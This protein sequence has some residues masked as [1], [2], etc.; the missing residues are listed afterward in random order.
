MDWDLVDISAG[1]L[2][3]AGIAAEVDERLARSSCLVITAPPGAGKSTLLPLTILRGLGGSGKILMLEPRRLAARQ[4][5]ERMSAMIGEPVGRTVGYRVRFETRVSSQ[6]RIEVLTEGILTRMLIADP[7]LEGVDAVVF[8]EFHERSLASDEALALTR[9]CQAL[10]R[11]DLKIVVM[12]ATIDA[13][14]VCSALGA[15]LVTCEGRMFTVEVIHSGSDTD[16]RSCAED[17]ARM[18]AVAHRERKGDI[19]AFL[20]GEG[21]I[22]RCMEII[23]DALGQTRVLPLYGQLSAEEQKLAIAPSRPG[24]RKVVL[25][26][27]VAETSITIEGVETVIDSGLCRRNVF[28]ARNGLSRLETVRISMDMADQRS[29]R[30]G[31]VAPGTCYRLWGRGTEAR[32][33]ACRTPEIAE[34]DLTPLMLD[35]AAWG[36]KD[37]DSLPWITPPPAF[38]VSQG[39]RLLFQLGATDA[40]GS[41][42]GTGRKMAS[43]P[44]HPRISRM[45]CT[46]ESDSMKA[47]ACDIAALLEEKDPMPDGGADIRTRIETLRSHGGSRGW[48]RIAKIA[49]QYRSMLHVPE[50]ASGEESLAA[51]A[52]IAAAYPE[53]IGK[54]VRDGEFMLASGDLAEVERTDEL[55]GHE[56]IAAASLNAR[57]G[58]VGKIFLG[59]PVDI[60]DLRHMVTTR[61]NISWDSRKGCVTAQRESR[62]GG[63]TVSASPIHSEVRGQMVAAICE[64][65]RKDG[66]AMLDFSDAVLNLQRRVAAVASWHP[67]L[68]LP[69]L[70]T[71]SVLSSAPQWLPLYVGR[72]TTVTELKKIDLVQALW[73]LLSYSQQM[74]VERLAPSHIEVPTGSRIRIEYRIGAEAPVLR[75]RLQE[76]FGL[77]DTPK[78]DGGKRP[79]LMELLSPGFKP[80]QLTS[81]LRSFWEGT[82]FEVRRELR[83]RYPKHSWPDNPLEAEAVRGVK[84][85]I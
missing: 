14:A 11:D 85:K 20:P 43:M 84:R 28:D 46:A 4:I 81:D 74:E 82:Y 19:L 45:L 41:I 79:V 64:A 71:E 53:R 36:E 75:V 30:A 54:S 59:A 80:V 61:D 42:T 48:S 25:A 9:Q 15:D 23:G 62:I 1:T 83:R 51:G 40:Q 33:A 67:E 57:A 50:G 60:R 63:L 58:G 29:G 16:A 21:E 70:G 38:R 65:A 3:A 8:D 6:T 44:C 5:A 17:V 66:T 22:R 73:G 35:I 32:M 77:L 47:L 2:P 37:V 56:W 18:A 12:S 34:A 13:E 10:L 78:V 52:L 49:R 31:R 39:R 72:A 55:A 24:E 76:C 27:P 26:T 69:D 7:A 68:E